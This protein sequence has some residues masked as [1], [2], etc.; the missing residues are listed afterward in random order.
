LQLEQVTS[1][2][3]APTGDSLKFMKMTLGDVLSAVAAGM[4]SLLP[5]IS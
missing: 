4:G 3:R 1:N 2:L 5:D